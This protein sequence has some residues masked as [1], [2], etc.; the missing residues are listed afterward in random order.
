MLVSIKII[1][2]KLWAAYHRVPLGFDFKIF[3]L[4]YLFSVHAWK[5]V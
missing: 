4:F 1:H 5:S 3:N 2:L